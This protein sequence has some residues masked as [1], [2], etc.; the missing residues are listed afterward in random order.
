MCGAATL[1]FLNP[2]C[3]LPERAMQSLLAEFATLPAKS[4]LSPLLVNE[5][6]TEQ[7]GSRR[8]VLTPWRALVEWAG[9]R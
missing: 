3:L 7:R 4:L 6:F 5:D 8:M 2:D 9:A 1:F